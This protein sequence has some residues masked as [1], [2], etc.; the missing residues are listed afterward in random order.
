[1]SLLEN[2]ALDLW[3]EELAQSAPELDQNNQLISF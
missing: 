2:K 3:P 1:M